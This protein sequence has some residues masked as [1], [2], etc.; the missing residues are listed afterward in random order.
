MSE[1]APAESKEFHGVRITPKCIQ[2]IRKGEATFSIPRDGIQALSIQFG[3][4]AERPFLQMIFGLFLAVFG[5]NQ[6]L[7]KL[8][9]F[10]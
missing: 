6:N 8:F 9:K 7:M 4:I 10:F 5:Q 2:T 3:F 1:N